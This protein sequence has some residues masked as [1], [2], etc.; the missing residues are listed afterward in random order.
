MRYIE[1]FE[2]EAAARAIAGK[3]AAECGRI[4]RSVKLME[5]CGSHTVAIHR[6]GLRS[7]FPPSLKLVSGPGCPVCVTAA[8]Y[9]DSALKLAK[10]PGMVTTTF[11]DMIRVPGSRSN[12]MEARAEGA[13]V[14]VCYSPTDALEVAAAN[15]GRETVF[16]GVGFETTIPAIASAVTEAAA[17][18]LG[19]F[20]VLSAFKRIPNPMRA[21]VGDPAL[22][23][24]GFICP[25]HVSAI[26]GSDAYRFIAEEF[27]RP[28]VVAGFEPLD[29]LYGVLGVLE[30]LAAGKSEVANQYSRVVKPS[31]NARA[32]A[33]IYEV[34][35]NCDADWRGL[36]PI[37]DSGCRMREKYAAFNAWKRF[38]ASVPPL[39]ENPG[40]RCGDVL[41]GAMEPPDCPLFG[42]ACS[43]D[44]PIGP[45]MVSSEGSCAAFYR[46]AGA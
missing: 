11:G 20:S 6:H 32:R 15:S 46:Y 24:D 18:G 14:R 36:G 31:G 8:D 43:P 5:V 42:G 37:P 2:N 26:I 40:C 27:K 10:L 7:L 23:I 4:G 34:F 30:M 17:K 1:G 21:L 28:C 9:V 13:D 22:A 25:A 44:T 16:L 35:E 3:I 41:R 33:A 12:L 39:M 29:I 38:D 19:N 45:C